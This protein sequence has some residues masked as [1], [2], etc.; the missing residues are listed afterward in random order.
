MTSPDTSRRTSRPRHPVDREDAADFLKS[1]YRENPETAQPQRERLHQVLADIE[2]TGTY[3]H[4]TN[5]LSWGAKTAWRNA[6]RCIG[7]LYWNSLQVRDRRRIHSAAGVAAECFDHL[8]TA[9][10]GGRIRPTITVFPADRP[11]GPVARIWNVLQHRGFPP[12]ADVQKIEVAR[13]KVSS[14]GVRTT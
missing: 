14:S 4:T 10:R 8:R 2:R 5:E 12:P 11:D 7:R 9:W 13:E 3:R 1:F 6:S